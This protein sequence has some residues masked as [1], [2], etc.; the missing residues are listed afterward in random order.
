MLGFG[1]KV[2][3]GTKNLAHFEDVDFLAHELF[4]KSTFLPSATFI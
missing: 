4:L 3:L 1:V 2:S